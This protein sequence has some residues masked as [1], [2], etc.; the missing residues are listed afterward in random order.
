MPIYLSV[1]LATGANG[2]QAA[3]LYGQSSNTVRTNPITGSGLVHDIYSVM[4]FRNEPQ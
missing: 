1:L 4:V 2:N 3:N